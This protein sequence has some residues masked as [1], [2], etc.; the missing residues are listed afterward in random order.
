MRVIIFSK[1]RAFRYVLVTL[2]MLILFVNKGYSQKGKELYGYFIYTIAKYVEWPEDVDSEKFT[3]GV[4]GNTNIIPQ[5]QLLA[6]KKTI[7]DKEVVLVK[8]DELKDITAVNMLFVPLEYS[9]QLSQ[10]KERVKGKPVLIITE[11]EGIGNQGSAVNFV[12]R[13]GKPAFELNKSALEEANLKVSDELL[14]FA[15]II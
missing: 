8:F 5:I 4:Y 11:K 15:I 9:S 6:A 10:I 12:Q 14:R 13:E 2:L 7:Q 1:I 3:I